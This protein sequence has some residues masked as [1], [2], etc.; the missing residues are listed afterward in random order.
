MANFCSLTP[1]IGKFQELKQGVE[2]TGKFFDPPILVRNGSLTVP[3][4]PGMGML[5]ADDLLKNAKTI[6]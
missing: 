1:N 4:A 5:H 3:H 2:E 6:I